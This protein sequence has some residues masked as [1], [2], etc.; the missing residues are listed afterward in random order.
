MSR[1]LPLTKSRAEIFITSVFVFFSISLLA[2]LTHPFNDTP[3]WPLKFLTFS[4]IFF[5]LSL[6][7]CL[8]L[9]FN[10]PHSFT[11]IALV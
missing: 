2:F 10:S 7:T 5:F 4:L 1:F 11:T 6:K 3:L 8:L 9:F